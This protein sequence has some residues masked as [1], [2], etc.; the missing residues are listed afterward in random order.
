[1]GLSALILFMHLLSYG[2]PMFRVD[3]PKSN[4]VISGTST[5]HEWE[6]D[7][8]KF[9]CD[10]SFLQNGDQG[11]S[12]ETINFIC[13]VKNI[14]SDNRVMDNKTFEALKG[15]K[16]PEIKFV[17]SEKLVVSKSQPDSKIKGKLNIAG[18]TKEVTLPFKM[19]NDESNLITVKGKTQLKMSDFGIEPPT[20]MLGTLK[21]GDEIEIS[22][23]IILKK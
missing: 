5:V 22:F 7:V 16:F 19:Q 6:I 2:Q 9:T 20:A 23:N 14:K 12:I 4:L 15:D 8:S 1:M 13:P 17:S 10:A 18:K 11:I 3:E 21:T